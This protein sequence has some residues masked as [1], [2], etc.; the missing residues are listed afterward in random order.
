MMKKYLFL[1]AFFFII[2]NSFSEI[3]HSFQ[4]QKS[5]KLTFNNTPAVSKIFF[6]YR[7]VGETSYERKEI[8]NYELLNDELEVEFPVSAGNEIEYYFTFESAVAGSFT[9]PVNDAEI[10]PLR[11]IKTTT[12]IDRGFV[13]ISPDENYY[14]RKTEV[15]I[16]ISYFSIA[17]KIDTNSIKF[18]INN[19]DKTNQC[20]ISENFLLYKVKKNDARGDLNFYIEAI[21]Q[22]KKSI[23]STVWKLTERRLKMIE[24]PWNLNGSLRTKL[25]NREA[26]YNEKTEK[27]ASSSIILKGNK[28]WFKFDSFVQ[29]NS[30]NSSTKQSINRYRLNTYLPHLQLS[31]G[32]YS[33]RFGTFTL[34]NSNIMGVYGNL[35]SEGFRI[36]A[37]AGS[38]IKAFEG[39]NQNQKDATFQRN[40]IGLRMEIGNPNSFNLGFSAV[41]NR[42]DLNSIEDKYD[43]S[44]EDD[45][46]KAVDN[47]LVGIDFNMKLSNRKFELGGEAAISFYNRNINGGVLSK[48]EFEEDYGFDIP[49][50]PALLEDIY[51][52]NLYSEPYLPGKGNAAVL[53]YGKT[54]VFGNLL[55]V[56]FRQVGPSYT[57]LS[58]HSTGQQDSRT[59]S[60]TDSWNLW[61]NQFNI[62]GGFTL[63]NDNILGQKI[64]NTETKTWFIN[65]NIRIKNLP[66]LRFSYSPSITENDALAEDKLLYEFD[67][68]SVS[69]GYEI[70]QISFVPTELILQYA[71]TFNSNVLGEDFSSENKSKTY[72][73][74]INSK[75][76]DFPMKTSVELSS[77]IRD[78]EVDKGYEIKSLRFK[79]NTWFFEKTLKPFAGFKVQE[80]AKNNYDG[81]SALSF[82]VGTNYTLFRKTSISTSF[83]Y[84]NYSDKSESSDSSNELIELNISHNF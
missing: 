8:E 71:E 15:V 39:D 32:D 58:S 55:N 78:E 80:Y 64:Y 26:S 27:Y 81:D 33:P 47:F 68:M 63:K 38:T 23:K 59:I 30:K 61:R 6:F 72:G 50:D 24:L 76:R 17:Q 45:T 19:K 28:K 10:N 12:N 11:F 41:Q 2:T 1:I 46:L 75:F 7:S 5:I 36:K 74:K 9:Y 70:S 40:T 22:S 25:Q 60:I 14:S 49:F 3:T 29:L 73:V 18:F 52:I 42:D 4:S 56:S 13:K 69:F 57:S 53:L 84:S 54:F 21:T 43:A 65:T 83:N 77:Y 82:F 35:H 31:F 20:T 34:N 79:T 44:A 66:Y 51:T 16:A 48:E 62:L 37:T 67:R